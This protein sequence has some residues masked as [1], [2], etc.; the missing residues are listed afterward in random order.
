MKKSIFIFFST[1]MFITAT[2]QEEARKSE[3]GVDIRG[4]IGFGKLIQNE[5]VN[6]NGSVNATDVLYFYRFSNGVSINGGIG[7]LEFNANGTLGGNSY[8]LE[9]F[10]LRIP[11]NVNHSWSLLKEQFNDKITSVIGVGIYG[12]TLLKEE[13]QTIDQRIKNQNQ[14]WNVG[15]AFNLG[16][17]FAVAKDF[18]FGIG[19]E[20][21]SDLTKMKK[22]G[23]ERKLDRINTV[24]FSIEMKF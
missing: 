17:R 21:Q 8:A 16:L 24:N 15:L 11:V 7:L 13:L 1:L 23:V 2:A 4:K 5:S 3:M 22:E 19:F 10:Y 9:Q 18:N 6:L 12:N 20:S 14:G